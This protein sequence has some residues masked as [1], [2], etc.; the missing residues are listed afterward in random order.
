MDGHF[1]MQETLA[2]YVR[3]FHDRLVPAFVDPR[4]YAALQALAAR[5]PATIADSLV[6]ETSLLHRRPTLDFS[7]GISGRQGGI[8]ELATRDPIGRAPVWIRLK[9]WAER[10]M[11]TPTWRQSIGGLWLEFDNSTFEPSL[12]FLWPP[13]VSDN[14]Q[15]LPVLLDGA[16]QLLGKV[17]DAGHVRRHVP[18]GSTVTYV[19]GALGRPEAGIRLCQHPAG[20]I[21]EFLK[22]V[23]W[24]GTLTGDIAGMIDFADGA[25]AVITVSDA[26]GERLGLELYCRG[27]DA[28]RRQDVMIAELTERGWCEPGFVAAI[29]KW[30][31]GIDESDPWPKNLAA[32]R[33][34]LG[35]R[36]Q[37]TLNS[38]LSHI[39]LSVTGNRLEDAKAYIWMGP[40][41]RFSRPA[42]S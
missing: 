26:I 27:E 13:P 41:W 17:T 12:F 18:P 10:W 1:L 22:T 42:T 3:R 31:G 37:C 24:S 19:G 32:R 36:A 38:A 9:T 8:A 21:E 28:A 35:P 7:I 5:I 29:R 39:K 11:D 4:G 33:A 40:V 30:R 20:S 14:G 16:I 2:S 23:S 6:F 15:A 34:I 25:V